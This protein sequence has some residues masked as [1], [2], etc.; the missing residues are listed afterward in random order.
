MNMFNKYLNPV[1]IETGTF[2]GGGVNCALA[3]GFKKIISIEPKIEYYDECSLKFKGEISDKRVTL[4]LG[5]SEDYLWP[6]IENIN[7]NITFWLD[8]HP[9][10]LEN[11]STSTFSLKSE[12]ETIM[13]HHIKSHTILIDDVRHFCYMGIDKEWIIDAVLK[14]NKNYI[15][16]YETVRTE[17]PNDVLVFS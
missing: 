7:T 1:F 17:F 3:S 9:T 15:V 14:N 10:G 5:K 6:I 11:K 13:K 4:V 8:G 2:H 12:I 16:K